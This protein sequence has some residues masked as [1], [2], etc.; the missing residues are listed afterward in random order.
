VLFRY[1][2][3][4]INE[5]I[6]TLSTLARSM[7]AAEDAKK[8]ADQAMEAARGA[9]AS[10]IGPRTEVWWKRKNPPRPPWVPLIRREDW[11]NH[12][13]CGGG[14]IGLENERS[15][16]E[17]L[18]RHYRNRADYLNTAIDQDPRGPVYVYCLPVN[19]T[20][21]PLCRLAALASP[22]RRSTAST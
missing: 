12:Y 5:R 8:M 4:E 2:K 9:D 16:E 15:H 22:L 14:Y 1:W 10:Y 3:L 17:H 13:Q 19:G 11:E 21:S 6:A 18:E 20:S 7:A